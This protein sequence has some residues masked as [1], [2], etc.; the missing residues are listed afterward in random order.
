MFYFIIYCI[1]LVFI[2]FSKS[3]TYFLNLNI[4]WQLYNVFSLII[5]FIL[6]TIS[7]RIIFYKERNCRDKISFCGET[8]KLDMYII[9]IYMYTIITFL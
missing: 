1:L 8:K 7:I 6:H 5:Y 4:T 9:I 2:K 3:I